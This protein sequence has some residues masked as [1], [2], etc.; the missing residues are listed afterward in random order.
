MAKAYKALSRR[1][2]FEWILDRLH[3]TPTG[4]M[5]FRKPL[6][7]RFRELTSDYTTH[8][9]MLEERMVSMALGTT[10]IPE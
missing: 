1:E 7:D 5:S 3:E 2:K 9:H 4:R 8:E 10:S 6:R